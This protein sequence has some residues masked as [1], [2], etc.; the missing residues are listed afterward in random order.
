MPQIQDVSADHAAPADLISFLK[1]IPDRR[2]VHYP[3]WFLLLVAV[4]GIPSHLAAKHWA[5][6]SLAF[7][8]SKQTVSLS[9]SP[10]TNPGQQHQMTLVTS[11]AVL[12]QKADQLRWI[13]L[14]SRRVVGWKLDHRMDATL[15]IEALNR[16]LG[17]RRVE[18]KQLLV[19]TDQGSHYR[20]TDYRDLL[21]EHGLPLP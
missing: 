21:Q 12:T 8:R 17:H 16:A 5:I 3:Q 13:D 10:A 15:A 20:A 4:L 9:S 1:A 2:G 18:P 7:Q 14:F 19:H 11:R 6:D